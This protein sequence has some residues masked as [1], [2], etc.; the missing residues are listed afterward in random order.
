MFNQCKPRE[1]IEKF[2]TAVMVPIAYSTADKPDVCSR[3]GFGAGLI[4]A[5]SVTPSVDGVPDAGRR[6]LSIRSA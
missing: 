5:R 6:A 1:A 3:C 4:G 2:V